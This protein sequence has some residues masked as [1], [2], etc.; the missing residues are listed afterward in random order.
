MYST[1]LEDVGIQC[2]DDESLRSDESIRLDSS[3]DMTLVDFLEDIVV[4]PP[5]GQASWKSSYRSRSKKKKKS[6]K[7]CKT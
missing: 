3:L 5:S 1:K 7:Q 4:S 2:D 6:K